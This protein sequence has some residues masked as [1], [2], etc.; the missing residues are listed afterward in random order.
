[1]QSAFRSSGT[2]GTIDA[3]AGGGR[4]S[5]RTITLGGAGVQQGPVS[6]RY[7]VTPTAYQSAGGPT[8]PPAACSGAMYAVVPTSLRRAALPADQP[9]SRGSP[10]GPCG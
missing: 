1:M 8:S 3:G 9:G 2:P 6:A 5:L 10:P 4:P 7:K